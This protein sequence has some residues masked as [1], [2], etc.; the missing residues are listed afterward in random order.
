MQM[1]TSGV[2]D[3][4][5]EILHPQGDPFADPQLFLI[6]MMIRKGIIKELVDRLEQETQTESLSL[7]KKTMLQS[8]LYRFFLL[9]VPVMKFQPEIVSQ[10]L[11]LGP[12]TKQLDG[13]FSK[14]DDGLRDKYL[15]IEYLKYVRRVVASDELNMP[16]LEARQFLCILARTKDHVNMIS[17]LTAVILEDLRKLTSFK[18]LLK[19]V[20]INET[21]LEQIA[22]SCPRLASLMNHYNRTRNRRK[23]LSTPNTDY[24]EDTVKKSSKVKESNQLSPI[25]SGFATDPL[26]D[27]VVLR[28]RSSGELSSPSHSHHGSDSPLNAQDGSGHFSDIE[29]LVSKFKSRKGSDDDDSEHDV[30]SIASGLNQLTN[31]ESVFSAT[32]TEKKAPVIEIQ[33]GSM[34][35]EDDEEEEYELKDGDKPIKK[36]FD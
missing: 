33:I 2:F 17:S 1:L 16:F 3:M 31:S 30:F 7:Q 20:E 36:L 34:N 32:S 19:W 12:L 24:L 25:D 21:K 10:E 15:Q 4:F 28:K 11:P 5:M 8:Y 35:I 27:K 18:L 13:V 22:K 9:M 6:T 23:S 26:D 14:L 29:K